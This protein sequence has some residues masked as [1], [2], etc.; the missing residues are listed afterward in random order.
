MRKLLAQHITLW[1]KHINNCRYVKMREMFGSSGGSN[2]GEF[3]LP[4]PHY[5][6]DC[7]ASHIPALVMSTLDMLIWQGTTPVP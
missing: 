2:K 7:C 6:H 5:P 4:N 3:Q 1:A